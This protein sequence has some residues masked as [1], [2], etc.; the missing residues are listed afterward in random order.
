MKRIEVY[1]RENC[2]A[3]EQAKAFLEKHDLPFVY[4]DVRASEADK[5]EMLR[6][7][8]EAKTVPQVFVGE[9]LIGGRDQL[10]ALPLSTLQQMIGE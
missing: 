9:T 10:V 3:C 5:A 4:R 7:N 2:P 8:P 6:R 1:G